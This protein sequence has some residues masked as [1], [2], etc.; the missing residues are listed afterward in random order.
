MCD[1]A[2]VTSPRRHSAALNQ[3]SDLSVNVDDVI[4]A[5]RQLPDRSS[6]ADLMPTSV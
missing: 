6:A 1:Q 5:V 3:A 4:D 2:R